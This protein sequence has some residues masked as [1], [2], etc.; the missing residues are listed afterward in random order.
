[1]LVLKFPLTSY[2]PCIT[3]FVEFLKFHD[4]LEVLSIIFFLSIGALVIL[5]GSPNTVANLPGFANNNASA[6]ANG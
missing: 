3:K 1:M 4:L 6:T 5:V 2:V